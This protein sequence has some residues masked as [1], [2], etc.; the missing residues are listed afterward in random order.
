MFTGWTPFL[1]ALHRRHWETARLV[2]AIATA[3][4]QASDTEI[5]PFDLTYDGKK[6]S[7]ITHRILVRLSSP[8]ALCR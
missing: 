4:Y 2:I 3:Q 7:H 1:V 5:A 8:Y 6:H